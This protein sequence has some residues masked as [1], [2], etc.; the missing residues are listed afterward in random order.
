MK[1]GVVILIC[2]GFLLLLTLFM[3]GIKG[4]NWPLGRARPQSHPYRSD[5]SLVSDVMQLP[6]LG[7][8]SDTRS[9]DQYVSIAKRM[10]E[11]DSILVQSALRRLCGDDSPLGLR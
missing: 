11:T 6:L 10:K 4:P 9:W 8:S 1:T 7:L 3:S 5:S 2:L